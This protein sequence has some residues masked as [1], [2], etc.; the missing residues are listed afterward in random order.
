MGFALVA[1][2][3]PQEALPLLIAA[4]TEGFLNPE[5]WIAIGSALDQ[6]NRVDEAFE[7]YDRALSSNLSIDYRPRALLAAGYLANRTAQ[8]KKAEGYFSELHRIQPTAPDA[9]VGLG[10]SKVKQGAAK[11]AL[12][13]V[14]QAIARKPHAEL[15]F[16][17]AQVNFHLH[18]QKSA[19]ED[20][21]AA[22]ARDPRNLEYIGFKDHI[23]TSLRK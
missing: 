10:L 9:I 21:L 16:F 13:I 8:Y 22:L 20:V 23:Q 19:N 14:T 6:M 2:R 3:R 5:L 1:L 4:K 12:D 17:R 7:A 18:N 15:F 11:E